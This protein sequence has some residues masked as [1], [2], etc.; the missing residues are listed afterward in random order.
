MGAIIIVALSIFL[1]YKICKALFANT[2]AETIVYVYRGF[3]V[4]IFVL[5]LLVN[6]GNWLG[7]I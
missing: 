4:W 1:T 5:W 7:L 6:I 3:I 2:I